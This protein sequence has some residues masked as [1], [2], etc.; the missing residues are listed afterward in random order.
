MLG[1]AFDSYIKLESSN[2]IAF[3][4]VSAVLILVSLAILAIM[5]YKIYFYYTNRRDRLKDDEKKPKNEITIKDCH[6]C[7]KI[8]NK[9]IVEN[10][11]YFKL[12]HKEI[13]TAIKNN[14]IW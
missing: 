12:V 5:G 14:K 10:K 1:S 6:K 13:I 9:A 8:M 2:P 7:I 4:V 3:Y 11:E